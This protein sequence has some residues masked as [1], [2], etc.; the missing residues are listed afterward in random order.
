MYLS[1]QSADHGDGLTA[2]LFLLLKESDLVAGVVSELEAVGEH[3]ACKHLNQRRA[4]HNNM[5][6]M[7]I[8]IL[9]V[10]LLPLH[11]SDML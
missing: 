11:A 6:N 3:A 8:K 2:L 4:F 9:L 1:I 10:N 7:V 5:T